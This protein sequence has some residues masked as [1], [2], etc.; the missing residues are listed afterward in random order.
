M[1]F[2]WMQWLLTKHNLPSKLEMVLHQPYTPATRIRATQ[3]RIIGNI[4]LALVKF[5]HTIK[6]SC[7]ATKLSGRNARELTRSS[8]AA[9]WRFPVH[10]TTK[11][12]HHDGNFYQLL[13]KKLLQTKLLNGI[14]SIAGRRRMKSVEDFHA[15][16]CVLAKTCNFFH[17]CASLMIRLEMRSS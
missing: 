14:S 15:D 5:V 1:P 6:Y 12:L 11:A 8:H 16:L 13:K 17:K 7:Q 2:R 4:P 10:N 9:V 3:G